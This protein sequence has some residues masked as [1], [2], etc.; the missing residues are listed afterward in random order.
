MYKPIPLF[1]PQTVQRG[2]GGGG[3]RGSL[4]S[5]VYGICVISHVYKPFV[6]FLSYFQYSK[7]VSN[8]LKPFTTYVSHI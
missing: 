3:G 1:G 7:F 2:G 4:Y 5:V 6:K 8:M